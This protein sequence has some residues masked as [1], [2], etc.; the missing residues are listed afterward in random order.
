MRGKNNGVIAG[1]PLD[2]LASLQDLVRIE[3]GGR[4]V[5]DQNVGV[6]NNRLSEGSGVMTTMR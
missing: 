1:E 6:M 2:Q 3:A 4:L 5:E